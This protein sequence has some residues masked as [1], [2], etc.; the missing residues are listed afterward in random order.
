MSLATPILILFLFLLPQETHGFLTA[1]ARARVDPNQRFDRRC[2]SAVVRLSLSQVDES[3]A[4]WITSFATSH[5]GMSAVRNTLI[6]KAG[7]AAE[8]L[9]LVGNA[10]TQKKSYTHSSQDK[11]KLRKSTGAS[12]IAKGIQATYYIQD[13]S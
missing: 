9:G 1:C 7:V 3:L 12:T 8:A 4:F 6:G 10:D 2:N 5:I 13:F 11:E